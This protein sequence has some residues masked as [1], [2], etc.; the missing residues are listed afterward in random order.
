M[1]SPFGSDGCCNL[2]HPHIPNPGNE[3]L[4]RSS[5]VTARSWRSETVPQGV[6]GIFCRQRWFTRYARSEC[7]WCFSF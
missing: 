2:D 6:A 3:L 5:I 4:C 7:R 1:K